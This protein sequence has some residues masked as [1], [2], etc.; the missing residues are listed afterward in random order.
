MNKVMVNIAGRK[1]PLVG[2]EPQTYLNEIAYYV[3]RKMDGFL[4][5]STRSGATTA[6]IL[7]AVNITDE[8]FKEKKGGP[9][10]TGKIASM[11]D[12]IL[13]LEAKLDGK[14]AEIVVKDREIVDKAKEIVEKDKKIA[15]K[16]SDLAERDKRIAEKDKEISKL[17][18]LLEK[19][20]KNGNEA[21]DKK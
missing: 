18:G 13:E 21:K 2:S 17:K 14:N 6:A 9:D 15:D 4:K 20:Q 12:K 16:D 10:F 3:D 7:T 1:I 5:R 8:L 11:E 19:T